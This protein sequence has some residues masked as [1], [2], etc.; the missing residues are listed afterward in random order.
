M[1]NIFYKSLENWTNGET[2]ILGHTGSTVVHERKETGEVG[3]NNC[4]GFLPGGNIQIMGAGKEN[5]ISLG[6]LTCVVTEKE[7]R[8]VETAVNCK[9]GFY[10]RRSY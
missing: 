4:L 7:L 10:R 6:T 1:H 9:T 8:K 3:L 2:I 5:P